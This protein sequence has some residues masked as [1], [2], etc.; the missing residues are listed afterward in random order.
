M[1]SIEIEIKNYT[2]KE[3]AQLLEPGHHLTLS[4]QVTLAVNRSRSI[5][6]EKVKSG[7]TIYGVNTG[8]GKL[9]QV[10]ISDE[11]IVKLQKNLIL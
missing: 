5:L 3:I 1:K 6:E 2:T 11:D 9:S 7:A 8:F 10:K 4:N